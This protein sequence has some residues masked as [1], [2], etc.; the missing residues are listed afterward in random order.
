[1]LQVMLILIAASIGLGLSARFRVPSIPLMILAGVLLGVTG[2]MGESADLE[3][4]LLLGLTFLLFIIGA[5]LDFEAIGNQKRAAL[6]FGLVQ[7]VLLGGVS[8]G[9]AQLMDF[10]TKASLYIGLAI[11]SSSTLIVVTL[12]RRREHFFESFGRLAVGVVLLQD[13]LVILLLPVLTGESAAEAASGVGATAG[14]IVVAVLGSHWVAPRIMLRLEHE[15]ELLLLVMLALL[16][17]F[18]GLAHW[19]GLPEMTGA[20]LAGLTL[21]RFPVNGLVRGQLGSLADFFLALFFV[22]LGVLMGMIAPRLDPQ[23]VLLN[24]ILLAAI[25][26][27]APFLLVPLARR[28]GLTTRSSI[29][30][31]NLLAQSGELS[32]VV[33]LLGR[34]RGHIDES[35]LGTI[36]VLTVITMVVSPLISSDQVTWRIMHLLPGPRR[37]GISVDHHDHLIFIGCGTSTRELIREAAAA[38]E[39]VVAVDDDSAVIEKLTGIDGV[40]PVR[41]DGADPWLLRRLG[42]RDAKLI[43]S[44]MRRKTDHERLL[45]LCDDTPV[46]LRTFEHDIAEELRTKGAI[47]ISESDEA[48]RVFLKWFDQRNDD[49]VTEASEA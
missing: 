34:D 11:A 42:V 12:L 39:K 29:E 37:L 23:Q 41:G 31:T 27:L 5:E 4:T 46:I 44:T 10:D 47:V 35:V 49:T 25:L 16:F 6:G 1:M 9:A 36:V 33:V 15:E 38:G 28:F 2:W 7:F 24:G 14:L 13:L 17:G 30:V 26:L 32:L 3:N 45:R 18:V 48:E 22:S 43:V 8:V 40:E 20:F 19:L 21:S